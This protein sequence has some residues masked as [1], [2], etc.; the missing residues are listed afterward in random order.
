[1]SEHNPVGGAERPAQV[2]TQVDRLTNSQDRMESL[3]TQLEEKLRPVSVSRP[4]DPTTPPHDDA[5]IVVL[6]HRIREH[7]EV[8]DR[9]C[10]WI[11]HMLNTL[12]I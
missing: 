1:M 10:E 3:L 11:V 8:V 12:E 6:A 9:Q 4:M 7:T 5:E 2:D